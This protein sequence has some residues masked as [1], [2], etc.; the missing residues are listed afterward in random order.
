MARFVKT[1]TV[2]TNHI[3]SVDW[4]PEEEINASDEVSV[5]RYRA[6]L[7][8]TG[9][10]PPVATVLENSLGGTVIWAYDIPGSYI[11]TLAG[12]FTAN[13]TVPSIS[14]RGFARFQFSGQ[15]DSL[16][17]DNYNMSG[18]ESDDVLVS[19]AIEIVVYP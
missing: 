19:A 8:Q 17:L 5:K 14:L 2:L 6:L 16:T 18:V 13:K 3:S 4:T 9:T 15:P 12:A 10:D 7:T 11:A 1:Q